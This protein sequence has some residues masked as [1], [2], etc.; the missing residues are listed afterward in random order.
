MTITIYGASDDLIEV[1]G[2]ISEEFSSLGDDKNLLAFSDGTLL[3]VTYTQ[4]G[5]WRINTLTLCVGTTYEKDEA[6]AD[7]GKR[8]DGTPAYSD[9]V[10]LTGFIAWVVHGSGWAQARQPVDA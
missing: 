1:E 8:E 3:E 5:I 4:A 10:T 7:E 6:T 9:R 2:D